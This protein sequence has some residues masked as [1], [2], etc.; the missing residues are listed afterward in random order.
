M[1]VK[2]LLKELNVIT[3]FLYV[4]IPI[5]SHLTSISH[6]VNSVDLTKYSLIFLLNQFF[7]EYF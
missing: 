2:L 4:N 6:Y 3:S 1:H 5:H 7:S